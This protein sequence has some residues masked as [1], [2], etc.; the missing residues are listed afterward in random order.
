MAIQPVFSYIILRDAPNSHR[1]RS[2]D[3][4]ETSLQGRFVEIE[5]SVPAFTRRRVNLT[6]A[7]VKAFS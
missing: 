4:M 3:D 2:R 1:P 5:R 6:R 7:C